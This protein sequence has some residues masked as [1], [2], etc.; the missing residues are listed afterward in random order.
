MDSSGQPHI[1]RKQRL[2]NAT[3][4]IVAGQV[5][6]LTLVIIIAAVLGGIWLDSQFQTKPVY[7]VSLLVASVPV[8]VVAMV[9][10]A[11]AA[12]KRIKVENS[13]QNPEHS[14][15][16]AKFGSEEDD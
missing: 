9:F 15:E 14:K 4:A 3:L 12:V 11:R 10:I 8:S 2:M 13:K 16:A 7:T 5:G 6:C 1:D